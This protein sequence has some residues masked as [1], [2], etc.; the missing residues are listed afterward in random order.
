VACALLAGLALESHQREKSE[1]YFY[2]IAM[3]E[4]IIVFPDFIVYNTFLITIYKES[5]GKQI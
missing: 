4:R 1:N 3:N 5:M 2:Y